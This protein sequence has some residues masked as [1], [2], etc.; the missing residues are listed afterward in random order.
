MLRGE[1]RKFGPSG[2]GTSFINTK[3]VLKNSLG[4][5]L[6]TYIASKA[7]KILRGYLGLDKKSGIVRPISPIK[8][9]PMVH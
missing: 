3:N 5:Y 1:T 9:I 7:L 8:V 2:G 4:L 6:L